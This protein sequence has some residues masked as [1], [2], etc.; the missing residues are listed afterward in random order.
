MAYNLTLLQDSTTATDL[1]STAN[2]YTGGV[3][4]TIVIVAVFFIMLMA[5]KRYEMD[6][7]LV[8]SGFFCFILSGIPAF[9][10][11]VHWAVPLA[12]LALTAFT[13]MYM[14]V[15]KR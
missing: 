7:A 10:Q 1:I 6:K 13:L 11:W 3:L 15:T 4:I 12:F 5:L 9:L 14:V 8:A 2:T